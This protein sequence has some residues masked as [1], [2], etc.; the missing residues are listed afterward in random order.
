MTKAE[1]IE[2]LAKVEHAYRTDGESEASCDVCK[3]TVARYVPA[4]VDFVGT[5]LQEFDDNH[6][7]IRYGGPSD[8]ADAWREE[9]VP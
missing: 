1:L 7:D 4:I 5:W 6:P 8:F 9:M 3:D 2:R